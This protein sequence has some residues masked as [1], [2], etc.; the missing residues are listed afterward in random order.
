MKKIVVLSGKG[1]VG[2]SMVASVLTCRLAR[3]GVVAVDADVDAPN[4][5]LWL[6]Q[7]EEWER[8]ER[9]TV[10]AKPQIDESKC[11][12]CGKCAAMCLFGALE[13]AGNKPKLIPYFCEGCGMC[14]EVCPTGAIKLKPVVGAVIKEK[15]IRIGDLAWLLVSGQL[16]AG[17]AGSGKIVE[18][19]RERAEKKSI[20]RMVIDA[21]AGTGCPV[22]A[23]VRG[24]DFAVLVAEPTPASRADLIK[25]REVVGYF[26]VDYGV[27][28]NK[29]DLNPAQAAEI[30]KEAGNRFLGKLGYDRGIIEALT[31][32]KPLIK[33]DLVVVREL[34]KIYDKIKNRVDR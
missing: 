6:G 4:L 23:A 9:I 27:V 19:L 10:V 32:L 1:G 24:T 25:A 11:S 13:V 15:N 14:E 7:G 12:G 5:H 26:G 22:I 33:T 3:E 16:F 30:E 2:K 21:P 20:D 18:R 8:E 28:V 34:D 31:N 29:W 17:E